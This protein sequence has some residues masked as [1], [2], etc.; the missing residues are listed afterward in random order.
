MCRAFPLITGIRSHLSSLEKNVSQKKNLTDS[1]RSR[2]AVFL[3]SQ[4]LLS[5]KLYNTKGR[6][7]YQP[8]ESA[9]Y[10]DY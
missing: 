7:N 8:Q 1:K 2:N 5:L 10:S 9:D 3:G 4:A 6:R